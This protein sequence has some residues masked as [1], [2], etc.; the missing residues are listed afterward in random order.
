[1]CLIL[2]SIVPSIWKHLVLP[3]VSSVLDFTTIPP[4]PLLPSWLEP[5]LTLCRTPASASQQLRLCTPALQTAKY[6]RRVIFKQ[7][8]KQK[9]SDNTNSFSRP[10]Q[11]S[12]VT[13]AQIPDL[14]SR[15]LQCQLHFPL[16]L[17]HPLFWS[18]CLLN[19]RP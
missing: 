3:L 6:R 19:S 15:P 1:M 7:T 2:N 17:L 18:S 10:T 8:N 13:L 11:A 12:D 14:P 5:L 16:T 9:M 4:F